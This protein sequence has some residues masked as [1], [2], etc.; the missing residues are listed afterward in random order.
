MRIRNAPSGA[1]RLLPTKTWGPLLAL[2]FTV[3]ATT[4]SADVAGA[5]T[6]VEKEHGHI[7]KL[8]E[9]NA[10]SSEVKQAMDALVDYDDLARRT[11]GKP[12]PTQVPQCTNY[13]DQISPEKQKELTAAIR[14]LIEKNY[15][16]N[17]R[18]SKDYDVTYK[19]A[20]ETGE[21]LAKVRTEA[22]NK[23]K[24]RDPSVLID[25]VVKFDNGK[26]YAIDFITEGSSMVKN[27]YDQNA[28]IMQKD[29][30]DALIAKYKKKAANVST[31]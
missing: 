15:L 27:Y 14:A 23:V 25:Y 28:K 20:K 21:G 11:M 24:P 3:L 8:V 6:F 7:K 22:K 4:A 10:P 19:S 13:F 26:Y 16:K 17:M 5:Q 2:S 9:E 29:G 1:G 30:I 12:C 31:E 18:K